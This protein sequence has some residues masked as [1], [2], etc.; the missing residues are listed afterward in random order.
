MLQKFGKYEL[1]DL[2]GNGSSATVHRALD[3]SGG[4]YVAVKVFKRPVSNDKV[5]ES[6]KSEIE[7]TRRQ[8]HPNI[9]KILDYGLEGE[10]GYIVME[11]LPGSLADQIDVSDPMDYLKAVQITAEIAKGLEHANRRNVIHRDIKPKNILMPDDGHP[12]I[13]DFGIALMSNRMNQTAGLGTMSYM[14][15]E[16]WTGDERDNR[17]DIYA[18]GVTLFEMLSGYKPFTGTREEVERQHVE[19][20]IPLL[21]A[22]LGVPEDVADI[23]RQAMAKKPD[24]RYISGVK[25]FDALDSV[26][27]GKVRK[28]PRTALTSKLS[29][30]F[31]QGLSYR[32]SGQWRCAVEEY[33]KVIDLDENSPRAY[34][35]RGFSHQELGQYQLAVDDYDRAIGLAPTA[36]LY[37]N[38]GHCLTS[39]GHHLRAINDYDEAIKLDVNLARAYAERALSYRE[40]G[41]YKQAIE[42]YD[43]V[44]RLEPTAS[45]YTG[46][47]LS[48]QELGEFR[49]AIDDFNE[50]VKLEPLTARQ[51]YGNRGRCYG[52][53]GDHQRAIDDYN[54]LIMLEPANAEAFVNRADSYLRIDQSDRAADDFYTAV[55]LDPEIANSHLNRDILSLVGTYRYCDR[56]RSYRRNDQWHQAVYEYDK[57]IR[58]DTKSAKAYTGRGLSY[59]ELAEYER[60][61][62]DFNEAMKL[63]RP[64]AR[65]YG[66]RG[67]CYGSI[68][69]HKRAIGDYDRAIERTPTA[70]RYTGRGLSRHELGEYQNAIDDHDRAIKLEPTALRYTARG[71]SRHELGEYQNAIDDYDRAIRM[72]PPARLDRY[73]AKA[74]VKLVESYRDQGNLEQAREVLDK[75]IALSQG[76]AHIYHTRAV[77]LDALGYY[78]VALEDYDRVIELEATAEHYISRGVALH[79]VGDSKQAEND[80]TSAIELSPS[81]ANVRDKRG[82]FYRNTR[83]Y[84]QAIDDYT[85]AI[86]LDPTAIRYSSLGRAYIGLKEYQLAISSYTEAIEQG[87]TASRYFIRG[88][89]Y[90]RLGDHQLAI[91]DFDKTVKLNSKHPNVD[92]FRKKSLGILGQ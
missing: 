77:V 30:Y 42:D 65:L 57:A 76:D 10:Q 33:N 21:P 61:I 4:E 78:F 29:E 23:V 54:R 71:L 44:I 19:S 80:F 36:R 92:A 62:D 5:R 25:M 69:D 84:R 22:H 16:L 90:Q 51:L 40:L 89:L 37:G 88:I 60:A 13:S 64:N 74:Y 26:L 72:K 45:L 12:K 75:A 38:R 59:L 2:I 27:R 8:S 49:L 48:Y 50:A 83:Q 58:L 31:D 91:E 32:K 3:S 70:S 41:E 28:V 63:E 79:K 15:P 20:P 9:V 46:R 18:L 34:S 81:D 67:Q 6:I 11:L 1:Q 7:L 47:G 55:K 52:S 87:P 85:E 73:Y 43:Q 56:G 35:G 68:G 14:A 17:I 66:S 39:L 82:S 86:K 53:L 24:S